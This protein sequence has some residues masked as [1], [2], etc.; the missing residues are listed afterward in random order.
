M[1]TEQTVTTSG[2][3]RTWA[4]H[5]GTNLEFIFRDPTNIYKDGNPFLEVP[6][7]M[8]PYVVAVY[9]IVDGKFVPP[10]IDFLKVQIKRRI[11]RARYG[12]EV[13]NIRLKDG[14]VI[15]TNRDA[16]TLLTNVY[17]ALNSGQITTTEWKHVDG[18]FKTYG[19]EEIS[20]L[21]RTVVTF[22]NAMRD[23][24]SRMCGEIDLL[25]DVESLVNYKPTDWPARDG[26]ELVAKV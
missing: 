16:Q 5:N 22:V 26:I 9:S 3:P 24:E 18:T 23:A 1:A 21:Y 6:V 4:R 15:A 2:R 13:G 20:A 7:E 25:T 8:L 19:L 11:A 17:N 12:R 14:T 10:S